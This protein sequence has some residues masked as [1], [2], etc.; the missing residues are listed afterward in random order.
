MQRRPRGGV[1]LYVGG[2]EHA[3]L[4]LLYARFWHKVLYD[5]GH[6]ST[7]EP[8]QRLFNQGTITAAAYIDERGVYVEATEVEERD[9]Q[10]FFDGDGGHAPA[11]GK[12]GKS[13]KN[14]VT[15]D[16]IYRDYGADTLRLY[17]MFMGPLD[18]S[19]P[20]EHRRHRRRAPVP[21]ALLAQRG[22]RGDRRA[23]RRPTCPP[24]T[25]PAACCTARS[26]RCGND[27]GEA[28]V[29]HRDRRA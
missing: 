28:R 4:H 2:A 3:V 7:P 11:T 18:A 10:C 23:P 5:L 24:T 14:A 1:D 17:E 15:P 29:Q 13:L 8:F 12:M 16:D 9:G 22:R 6:V 19:R 21:P 25:R 20:V 26:T 27:M